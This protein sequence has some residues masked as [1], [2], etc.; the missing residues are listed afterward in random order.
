[1][2]AINSTGS[3]K[4]SFVHCPYSFSCGFNAPAVD[5]PNAASE[6]TPTSEFMFGA[7]FAN[8]CAPSTKIFRPGP[9][10]APIASVAPIHGCANAFKTSVCAYSCRPSACK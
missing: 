4:K 9:N 8:A 7:P 5:N 3:S 10:S 6:P 1:M 2:N